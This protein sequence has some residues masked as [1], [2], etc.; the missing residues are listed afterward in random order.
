MTTRISRLKHR[1]EEF[2]V[3]SF[4]LVRPSCFAELTAAELAV[5]ECVLEGSSTRKIA[6]QLALSERTVGNH[7]AHVYRKLGI[8]SRQEL[9][10]LASRAQPAS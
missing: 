5:T 9:L 2:I 7:L 6:K 8:S 10:A 3:C 4:P 1:G